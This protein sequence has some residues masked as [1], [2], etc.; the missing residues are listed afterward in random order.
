[1]VLEAARPQ[2]T[3]LNAARITGSTQLCS[4]SQCLRAP[5]KSLYHLPFFFYVLR[6][7]AW[8]FCDHI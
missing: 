6:D 5:I 2:C 8:Y 4:H 3:S 1:M 7:L